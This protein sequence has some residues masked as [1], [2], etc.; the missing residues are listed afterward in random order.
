M[1]EKSLGGIIT[2]AKANNKLV[3][4]GNYNQDGDIT[5]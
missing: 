5:L 4:S 2:K 3:L 1:A